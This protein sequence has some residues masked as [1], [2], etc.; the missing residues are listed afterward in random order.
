MKGISL[1]GLYTQEEPLSACQ[2]RDGVSAAFYF[3]PYIGMYEVCCWQRVFLS[4]EETLDIR[5]FGLGEP[6]TF[7]AE[8]HTWFRYTRSVSA[9]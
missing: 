7:T 2:K 8:N 4:R 3:Y 1:N 9:N 5:R 6:F